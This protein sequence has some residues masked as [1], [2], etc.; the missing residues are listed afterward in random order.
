M[1]IPSIE[2]VE[3]FLEKAEQLNSGVWINHCKTAGNCA[4]VIAYFCD[5]LDENVAYTMGVLHDIGRR[6]GVM[7]MRHIVCGYNYM[8]LQ[9]YDDIARICLTHS[10][11]DKNILSYNGKN[12]CTPEETEFI[13]SFIKTVEYNDY[14]RLIQLCDA[15]SFPE[16]PT[17]MEK[18]FVDVA[19]RRGINEYSV[20]KWKA[21]LEIKS[22]FDYKTGFNIYD[23]FKKE[24]II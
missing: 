19:I 9:G 11:P 23:L 24:L 8:M 13:E 10:F 1:K 5:N 22:Y 4:K 6:E 7:D 18:R 14:D 16:G 2:K 20:Q 17:Y 21:F 15:I 3:E 12:D